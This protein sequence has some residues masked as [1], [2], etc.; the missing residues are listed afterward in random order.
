MEA[1]NLIYFVLI[2]MHRVTEKYLKVSCGKPGYVQLLVGIFFYLALACLAKKEEKW[3]EEKLFFSTKFC[4][5][6]VTFF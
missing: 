4:L 3:I 1:A 6:T 2:S 5:L